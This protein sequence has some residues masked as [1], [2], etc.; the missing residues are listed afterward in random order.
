M[1]VFNGYYGWP[2]V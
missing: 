1:L 2:L